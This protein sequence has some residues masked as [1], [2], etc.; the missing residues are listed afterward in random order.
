M[1]QPKVVISFLVLFYRRNRGL[2]PARVAWQVK[3]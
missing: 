2:I 3:W 1:R